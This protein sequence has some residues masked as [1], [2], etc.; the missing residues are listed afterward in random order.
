ML[1]TPRDAGSHMLLLL[2][3]GA[4]LVVNPPEAAFGDCRP[5]LCGLVASGNLPTLRWPDFLDY[6][7]RVQR[8]YEP[9]NYAF[10]WSDK[11]GA[12]RQATAIIEIL[13]DADAKGLD[14]EDYDG[15]RWAGRLTALDRAQ[16]DLSLTVSV[17]RYISDL[18]FGKVNPGLF[19][20]GS[21]R[22]EMYRDDLASFVRSLV[23]ATD[24]RRELDGIEPPYAGYRRTQEA[25]RRYIA[26]A[27]EEQPA[28]LPLTKKPVDPGSS[29]AAAAQLA[30]VLRRLGDLPAD[31]AVAPNTYE[32]A[33]VDAVRHFQARHGLEPD[34]RLGKATLAQLNTPIGHRVRQLQLTL[35][36]WR[37]V[38]YSFP[39]PPVVVNIPE[40]E[41]RALNSSYETELEMKVVVG[42]AFHHQTPVFT[43]DMKYVIFR[44]YW[45]VPRSIQRAELVPKL[46]RDRSYLANNGYEV[47]T[48]QD[49]VVTNGLVDDALLAQLRSGELRIRQIPGPENA[50]GLVKFLFP[51]EHDVY[52]HATP[53]TALFSKYRRDFSHGCIRV[54]KPE[55]LAAWVL[56]E[57]PEWTPERIRDAMDGTKTLQVTLDTPIPVLIVYATAVVL[58]SGEVR[59]LEDIYGQDVQL[60]RLL[61]KGYP[62]RP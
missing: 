28:L 38:P 31:A 4:S 48:A 47:V 53:A 44:P 45:N 16:F 20:A 8:F 1:Y 50:L 9:T 3:I 24:V 22:D 57:K 12:T 30:A 11:D 40:F 26:L 32:G 46:D 33:L 61:A 58:K 43:A 17:M 2:L 49:A 10:A 36:R 34:G 18:H 60:D 35:E 25:L 27:R 37:W 5:A 56:R 15:S 59:F 13:K 62:Y 41:L 29:Y 14:S 21:D 7:T 55:Q 19:Q 23:T 52:L 42:K 51:N 54:E 6:Q 39:R